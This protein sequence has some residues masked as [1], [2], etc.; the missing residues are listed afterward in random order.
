MFTD[1]GEAMLA[2]GFAAMGIAEALVHTYDITQGL[3]V[4]WLPPDSL[5][6]LVLARLLP[7]SPPGP[8]TQILLWATGRT[9]LEGHPPVDEWVWR[10]A[11][12]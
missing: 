11:L 5:S 1:N 12:S 10:P 6:Q 4:A 8:A 9:D 3:G 2:A 7:D